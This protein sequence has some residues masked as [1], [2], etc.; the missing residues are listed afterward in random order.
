MKNIICFQL[1]VCIF[2]AGCQTAPEI[3]SPD[4]YR[5]SDSTLSWLRNEQQS[6]PNSSKS[7][8]ERVFSDRLKENR[9]KNRLSGLLEQTQP[10]ELSDFTELQEKQIFNELYM[11]TPE[12][13]PRLLQSDQF[14]V[15]VKPDN[16]EII[17]RF[18]VK[19]EEKQDLPLG[20][21][22]WY[23]RDGIPYYKR[24]QKL[25][26]G[27]IFP[28]KSPALPSLT[29]FENLLILQDRLARKR[30][31]TSLL[32]QPAYELRRRRMPAY[33]WRAELDRQE[34]QMHRWN[35][36]SSLFNIESSL[37]QHGLLP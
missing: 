8:T 28:Y 18:I 34:Q 33:D 19:R 22:Y 6:G 15:V 21:Y 35:V 16:L 4:I 14:T 7:A 2:F 1:S 36:E 9:L 25:Q 37:F 5:P 23:R 30:Q 12:L 17:H 11:L 10:Q 3:A 29:D 26:V 31:S 32:Q 27:S 24:R 20:N 13:A